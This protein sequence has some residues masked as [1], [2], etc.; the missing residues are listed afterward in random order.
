M[1]DKIYNNILLRTCRLI[2][3]FKRYYLKNFFSHDFI[4]WPTGIQPFPLAVLW[5][6]SYVIKGKLYKPRYFEKWFW[7]N[8]LR[9]INYLQRL[10]WFRDI[11]ITTWYRVTNIKFWFT[12]LTLMIFIMPKLYV[13]QHEYLMYFYSGVFWTL[14][15]NL[16]S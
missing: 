3:H 4:R 16:T 12:F 8:I 9:I 5:Y 15:I 10:L 7:S 13:K 2:R 11:V 6:K 14:Y 1:F